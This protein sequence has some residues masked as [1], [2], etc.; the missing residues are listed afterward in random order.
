MNETTYDISDQFNQL[1]AEHMNMK[2]N[3]TLG[4]NNPVVL[5]TILR[6]TQTLNVLF[7]EST[8]CCFT[9]E[10]LELISEVLSDLA[11]LAPQIRELADDGEPEWQE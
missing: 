6:M 10:E 7:E 1:A 3:L 9:D 4:L 11:Y 8:P 5:E 2:T